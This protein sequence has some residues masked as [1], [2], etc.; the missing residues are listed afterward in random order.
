MKMSLWCWKFGY[1]ALKSFGNF[2][3]GIRADPAYKMF[4]IDFIQL[5]LFFP[6]RYVDGE[7]DK[8]GGYVSFKYI[9]A[10]LTIPR[11]LTEDT[12]PLRIYRVREEDVEMN[13]SDS[14]F[15]VSDI[16]RVD[17]KFLVDL[18]NPAILEIRCDVLHSRIEKSFELFMLEYNPVSKEWTD[19][20]RTA[21]KRK[22]F[23]KLCHTFY[24]CVILIFILEFQPP[25]HLFR[26]P[27]FPVLN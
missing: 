24:W 5:E 15:L 1:L 12:Q 14:E 22:R 2:S 17:S 11:N 19:V 16:I 3:K 7:F 26:P 18:R 13:L 8:T 4:N 9:N 23:C 6:L 10:S 25:P 21:L 27:N 20:E